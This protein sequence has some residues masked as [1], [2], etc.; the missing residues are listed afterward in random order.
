M[1]LLIILLFWSELTDFSKSLYFEKAMVLL[2]TK[3]NH[4]DDQARERVSI[5]DMCN[6]NN[7]E[8]R[9]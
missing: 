5:S 6:D 4:A 9:I 3:A 1:N 7:V 2:K 8:S